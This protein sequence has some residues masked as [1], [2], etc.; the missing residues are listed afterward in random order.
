M[1]TTTTMTTKT[2]TE[3][4]KQFDIKIA[5]IGY[6]SVGK[7]TLLNALF[8]KMYSDV[9]MK[10]ST[11]AVNHFRIASA[12]APQAGN[13]TD[14]S[15]NND[16]IEI[17]SAASTLM[18][19]RDDNEKLRNG[20]NGGTNVTTTVHEK[21]F[22]IALDEPLFDMR[23]DTSLVFV[24]IPGTNEA[25]GGIYKDYVANNWHAFDC[26]I[27]VMDATQGANTDQ[28]V[29]LLENVRDHIEETQKQIPVIVVGN[30]VDDPHDEELTQQ[31]KEL[32]Q[33][34]FQ[35]FNES[36]SK[37]IVHF[38]DVSAQH[39]FVC[40]WGSQL[41]FDEFQ[42]L[43]K[44]LIDK[45]GR[46]E[47][48]LR[49][50][51]RL[52]SNRNE[53]VKAAY[54]AISSTS[55][56]SYGERLKATNFDKFLHC[57][58]RTLGGSEVQ[59]T[60]IE[61][62]QH[63]VL[64]RLWKRTSP[65]ADIAVVGTIHRAHDILAAL[66]KRCDVVH[67]TFWKLYQKLEDFAFEK[68]ELSP[69]VAVLDKPTLFLSQY[70][71][72]FIEGNKL[73]GNTLDPL[74]TV[75][76]TDAIQNLVRRQFHLIVRKK[77][78]WS[79]KTWYGKKPWKCDI[80]G[81]SWEYLSPFDWERIIRSILLLRFDRKFCV[82]FGSEMITLETMMSACHPSLVSTYIKFA[83]GESSMKC[84]VQEEINKSMA[85]KE[86]HSYRLNAFGE[87]IFHSFQG[88]PVP[89]IDP[90]VLPGGCPDAEASMDGQYVPKD[91]SFVPK[92]ESIYNAFVYIKVPRSLEDPDHWGHVS[93]MYVQLAK[94]QKDLGG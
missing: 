78:M 69:E 49:Q 4:S 20:K 30:K 13:N 90:V 82:N 8:G 27:V 65:T 60:A 22:T 44:E 33:A 35:V 2:T 29:N 88:N 39:A 56:D 77:T 85:A 31:V 32:R 67:E 18:E 70:H 1:A 71:K 87:Q 6:V 43:D 81:G 19:T 76:F 5:V 15:T 89:K 53:Q 36:I 11:A 28:Q 23:E 66:G 93:W 58:S 50:W 72:L 14:E 9:K 55:D 73:E 52:Q 3:P 47:L 92:Y 75:R 84:H 59:K 40:R 62:Q 41:K 54:E 12:T 61:Q 7:S 38:V 68:L 26:V 91:N 24:D 57:L 42:Q 17:R 37:D 16:K 64:M 48:G 21:E 45:I 83:D 63:A 51:R 80:E 34:V 25:N 79:F 74:S 86:V 46:E 10:R 94:E